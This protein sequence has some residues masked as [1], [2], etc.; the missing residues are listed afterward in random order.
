MWCTWHHQLGRQLW[1][2]L[3]AG[4][5]IGTLSL[6]ARCV[7]NSLPVLTNPKPVG[8]CK[9]VPEQ[10]TAFN[11]AKTC[12][13]RHVK[14][15]IDN[16]PKQHPTLSDKRLLVTSFIYERCTLMLYP[17]LLLCTVLLMS[18]CSKA[19]PLIDVT[20]QPSPN[21][22]LVPSHKAHSSSRMLVC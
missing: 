9:T 19:A 7:L 12:T 3:S 4:C 20:S 2:T 6:L 1:R 22:R 5:L 15:N 13:H 14:C 8:A 18:L 11:P 17:T 10:F 16:A 21:T